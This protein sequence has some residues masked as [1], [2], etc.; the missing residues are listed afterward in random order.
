MNYM[1][2]TR[3]VVIM[4]TSSAG[5]IHDIIEYQKTDWSY[6]A[7]RIEESKTIIMNRLYMAFYP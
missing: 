5:S 2:T 1:K 3:T 7:L 4:T 6:A